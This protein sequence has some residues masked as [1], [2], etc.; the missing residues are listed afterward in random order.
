MKYVVS[1]LILVFLTLY[2]GAQEQA[3]EPTLLLKQIDERQTQLT[4]NGMISLNVW[5][6]AN[7][8]SGGIGYFQT[9]GDTR[10]FHQMNAFWNIVNVGIAVPG[11]IGTYKRKNDELTFES[12]YKNQQKL[13]TVYL[14]NAA[15]DVGYMASGWALFNFGNNQTGELRNRFRGYG[16][17]L[18]LQG[19]YLFVYDMVMFALLKRTGKKLDVMWKNVSSTPT[20][21]GMRINF[22]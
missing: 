9:T 7:L 14:F 19:G 20:G 4:R 1:A 21:L 6:G 18:V 13:Q 8:I 3:S 5:A 10:Y 17:S 12:V 22:H 15:L 11:L 16:Q 2:A